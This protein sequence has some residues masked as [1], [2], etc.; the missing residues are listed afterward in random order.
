MSNESKKYARR[1]WMRERYFENPHPTKRTKNRN[2]K[3]TTPKCSSQSRSNRLKRALLTLSLHPTTTVF[4]R[5]E[6]I[7]LHDVCLKILSNRQKLSFSC[8]SIDG[9]QVQTFSH[10]WYPASRHRLRREESYGCLVEGRVWLGS[11][12]N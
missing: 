1:N 9:C 2:A 5:R 12:G 11:I 10:P 7:T 4:Q 8:F 6:K 3:L